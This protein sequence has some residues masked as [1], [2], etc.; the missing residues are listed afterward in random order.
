M[1]ARSVEDRRVK[2]K[3]STP[4]EMECASRFLQLPQNAMVNNAHYMR[5]L[6][7]AL[8]EGLLIIPKAGALLLALLLAACGLLRPGPVVHYVAQRDSSDCG[9]A[10]LTMLGYDG[11]GRD[12]WMSAPDVLGRACGVREIK[13]GIEWTQENPHMLVLEWPNGRQHWVVAWRDSIYDPANGIL[14]ERDLSGESVKREFVVPFAKG[15]L[16]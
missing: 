8:R 1:A 13:P 15:A 16:R 6:R 4:K 5:T 11:Y 12:F 10:C 7:R 3:T 2:T 9:P 14:H